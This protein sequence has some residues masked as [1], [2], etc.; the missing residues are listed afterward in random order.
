MLLSTVSGG[1]G[2]VAG[3]VA[4]RW[5]TALYTGAID[6]PDTVIG[7]HPVTVVSG[8][9]MSILAGAFAAA[10]NYSFGFHSGFRRPYAVDV[11]DLDGNGILDVVVADYDEARRTFSWATMLCRRRL[12]AVMS[13]MPVSRVNACHRS[14][15]SSLISLG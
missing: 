9:V 2:L 10:V 1:L 5:V 15:L 13:R 12:W 4:G 8:L 11:G 3:L 7:F 14:T 6:V